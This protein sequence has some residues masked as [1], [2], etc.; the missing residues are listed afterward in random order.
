MN[1]TVF[2]GRPGGMRGARGETREGSESQKMQDLGKRFLERKLSSHNLSTLGL[3]SSTLVPSLRSGRRIAS[4]IPPGYCR[5]KCG[6]YEVRMPTHAAL[7][8]AW[9][10]DEKCPI[11]SPIKPHQPKMF[12]Q[13]TKIHLPTPSPSTKMTPPNH[14]NLPQIEVGSPK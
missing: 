5:G 2:G 8:N 13:T 7:Q 11:T 3:W 6:K 9:G 14:Q 12:P 10:H 1:L 4:R